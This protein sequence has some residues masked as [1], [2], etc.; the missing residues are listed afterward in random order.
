MP[1]HQRLLI[2]NPLE[3]QWIGEPVESR[4]GLPA[5]ADHLNGRRIVYG[6]DRMS[7]V[8]G[9]LCMAVIT[10]TGSDPNHMG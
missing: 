5:C 8:D 3:F 6:R 9:P 2:D 7:Q 1:I 4:E 10:K